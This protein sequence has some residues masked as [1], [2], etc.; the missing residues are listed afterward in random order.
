MSN[1]ENIASSLAAD[2][3]RHCAEFEKSD[4]YSEM[5]LA[6]V[7]SLYE[8]AIKDTFRWGNFPKAVKEALES[9]LPANISEIVDLPRYNLMMARALAE[10]WETSAVSDQLVK[11]MQDLVID[12]IKEDEIPEFIKASELWAAYIEQYQDEALHEG[13]E[14]PHVTVSDDDRGFVLVGFNKENKNRSRSHSDK[15]YM[16]EVYL[17]FHRVTDKDR[18]AVKQD[19]DE[20][21]TL[22]AGKLGHSDALGKKPVRFGSKF[23]RLVGA[24]YYGNSKL[25]MNEDP[26]EIYYPGHD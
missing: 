23:E 5:I 7:K 15:P 8:E 9:A 19:G 24:L 1:Q 20:F 12:F 16:C 10:S 17:G 11:Q 3:A 18:K 21:Y 6:A 26:T 13:W 14:H 2:I 25:I 22:Y 4:A